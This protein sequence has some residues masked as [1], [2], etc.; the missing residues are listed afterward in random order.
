MLT[1]Q[2]MAE[3]E[4]FAPSDL[5]IINQEIVVGSNSNLLALSGSFSE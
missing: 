1:E 3:V 4:Q 2:E 5:P